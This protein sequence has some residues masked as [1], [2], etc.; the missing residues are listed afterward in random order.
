MLC[1]SI[2]ILYLAR[3]RAYPCTNLVL[4][5]DLV[6]CVLRLFKS[7]VKWGPYI[8]VVQRANDVGLRIILV[9]Q[10]P[11]VHDTCMHVH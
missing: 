4:V 1:V 10:V 7:S 5:R 3:T 9:Y 6:S 11:V 8:L 2:G